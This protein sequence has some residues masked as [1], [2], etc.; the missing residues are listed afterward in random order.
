MSFA[1]ANCLHSVDAKLFPR[2][3]TNTVP[4]FYQFLILFQMSIAYI[5]GGI[6]K[7]NPDWLHGYPL[8]VWIE[9]LPN[10][11]I[12]NNFKNPEVLAYALSYSGLFFDLFIVLFLIFKKTRKIGLIMVAEFHILNAF[13]FNIGVFPYFSLV[14]TLLFLE[15]SFFIKLFNMLKFNQVKINKIFFKPN[16]NIIAVITIWMAIQVLVPL[17]SYI[18]HFNPKWSGVGDNF[19][20]RMRLHDYKGDLKY[21]ISDPVNKRLIIFDVETNS[22]QLFQE[23]QLGFAIRDPESIVLGAK[24]LA[25][26]YL[27]GSGVIPEVYAISNLEVDGRAPQSYIDP[28]KDLTRVELKIFSE[29]DILR[30]F[31]PNR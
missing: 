8:R 17:R 28:T 2:I 10:F 24:H 11:S 4:F 30:P 25:K 18:F 19:S 13:L 16:K 23:H 14:L 12:L 29:L 3:K 26:M 5:F 9:S 15:D 20:W 31:N 7:L 22:Y 21:K 1:P 27:E 6:A